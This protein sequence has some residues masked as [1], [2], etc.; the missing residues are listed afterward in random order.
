MNR[1]VSF[2][3]YI[4]DNYSSFN[5]AVLRISQASK[6]RAQGSECCRRRFHHNRSSHWNN[7]LFR[8]Q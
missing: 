2:G 8:S 4:R 5:C 7:D 1:G 3:C 6:E